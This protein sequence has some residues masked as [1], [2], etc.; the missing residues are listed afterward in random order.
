[1]IATLVWHSAGISSALMTIIWIWI[2]SNLRWSGLLLMLLCNNTVVKEELL[3]IS[4]LYLL[5]K[6]WNRS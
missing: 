5:C 6:L 4:S 2:C 1:V 3:F